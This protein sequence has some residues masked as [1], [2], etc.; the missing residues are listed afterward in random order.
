[1]PGMTTPQA[2][3]LKSLEALI[4]EICGLRPRLAELIPEFRRSIELVEKAQDP[5]LDRKS[6]TYWRLVAFVDSLIRLRLFLE[7]N[8]NYVET[9]G[10]LAVA[11]YLFELTVW[12][13]VLQMDSRYGLVY[14]RELLKKQLDFY[15]EFRNNA[16]REIS[17]L[18]ETGAQE[19]RLIQKRLAETMGMPDT[20]ARNQALRRLSNEVTQEI[21]RAASRR[22]SLYAEQAQTNGYDFQAHL[23]ETK[24][25]P[26]YSKAIAGLEQKLADFER[27]TPPDIRSLVPKRWN[28]KDQAERVDMK[29]EYDF[30]YAY[31]SRLL[32]ATPASLTTNQK[33]LEPDEMRAFL[34]YIQVRLLD[35]IEMAEGL[36][37]AD[38]SVSH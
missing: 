34:K 18:R 1:M 6:G 33:N 15:T 36:L 11:R 12:I 5:R 35:V 3:K 31:A 17:F 32:H 9:I 10:V 37:A 29:D 21:D 13:K 4:A 22:F 2:H 30:I 19:Q 23:I 28:W 16:V 7:H 27:D 26:E 24:V 38:S 25:L 20:E 14:Y 8:F